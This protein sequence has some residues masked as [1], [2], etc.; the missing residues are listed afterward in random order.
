M[1]E[2][3]S[4]YVTPANGFGPQRRGDWSFDV[5]EDGYGGGEKEVGGPER[6]DSQVRRKPVG[7]TP[8]SAGTDVNEQELERKAGKS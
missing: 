4:A 3:P 8:L 1:M 7:L 2:S 6:Q 5:S